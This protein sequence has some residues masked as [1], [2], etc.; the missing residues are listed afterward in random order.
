VAVSPFIRGPGGADVQVF[1]RAFQDRPGDDE[2]RPHR[3]EL[4]AVPIG[5]LRDHLRALKK[6][7]YVWST[8]VRGTVRPP[9]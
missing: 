7:P 8:E 9:A 6:R 3:D 2:P 1:W 5:T 4:C